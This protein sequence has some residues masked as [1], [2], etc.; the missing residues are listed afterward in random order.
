MLLPTA[1]GGP[2]A[3]S[4]AS[5]P[6]SSESLPSEEQRP[7]SPPPRE[8]KRVSKTS[9]IVLL[10]A[11]AAL[12]GCDDQLL[13]ASFRALET[14][15]KFHPS[16][17]GYV[18]LAQTMAL[19]LSCPLWGYLADKYPRRRVMAVGII[20]WGA[21]T[22][23]L[24][25]ASQIVH[26]IVLRAVNGLFLGS[27]GP[28]SQSILADVVP[29]VSRGL[30]FGLIQM[31]ASAG[32]VAGGVVTT[33]VSSLH[34]AGFY[35]W[36][37]TFL[38]VGC[39][40][41]VLGVLVALL[42]VSF[43]RPNSNHHHHQHA[44]EAGT[45]EAVGPSDPPTP[46][47]DA[48]GG[49]PSRRHAGSNTPSYTSLDDMGPSRTAGQ[50]PLAFLKE[51]VKQ[52]M[53]RP[54]VLLLLAEGVVGI[55][56]W[57]ALSFLTMF[58]QYCGLSDTRAGIAAGSLL[59]GAM[60]SGPVG[61]WVGDKVHRWSPNHGRPFMGQFSM[62]ARVP[63]LLL[64]F[65]YVPQVAASF[66]WFVG[67]GLGI[68]LCSI[69]GVVVNRPLLSEV[70][71]PD[72]RATTFAIVV[73]LEGASGAFFGAPGVGFLV[74]RVFGYIKTD[75]PVS[76][77]PEVVRQRNAAALG[78]ALLTCT[79][80]PWVISFVLYGLIH[81]TYGPDRDKVQ[82]DLLEQIEEPLVPEAEVTN[83]APL[84]GIF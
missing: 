26:V 29:D 5:R 63:L 21:A 6:E 39:L 37:W 36:R 43:A 2:A 60:I 51:V 22:I 47:L 49:P 13:P 78:K 53:L 7:K 11:A 64:G 52:S 55:I 34:F 62:L 59:F 82:R 14:E 76:Q 3:R 67:I 19:S 1:G 58:F 28:I 50:S 73:A 23:L 8:R 25:F 18:T 27:I 41:I 84:V 69:A 9:G 45:G 16:L 4:S 77:L 24:A 35:G 42:P 10:N 56:P 17:L 54:S 80:V 12:D 33:S 65:Y 38:A 71:R 31:C 66:G 20:S 75:V 61:G 57:S 68:G 15:L 40:S 30:Q 72:H 32:R 44:L 70:V 74:E 46:R 81:L 79:A 83:R 48:V